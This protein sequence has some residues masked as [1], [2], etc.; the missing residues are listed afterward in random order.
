[1]YVCMHVCMYVCM[2]VCMHVRMYSCM[3]AYMYGSYVQIIYLYVFEISG[4][5]AS[6]FSMKKHWK[7]R[8]T[9]KSAPVFI[10]FELNLFLLIYSHGRW[11]Q[12]RNTNHLHYAILA[13]KN[14]FLRSQRG[15]CNGKRTPSQFKN[16]HNEERFI[17]L[18][19]YKLGDFRVNTV[20][21]SEVKKSPRPTNFFFVILFIFVM[22]NITMWTPYF[23]FFFIEKKKLA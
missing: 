15:A 23:H 7:M 22:A 10:F 17:K 14:H 4:L 16:R 21:W 19:K 13:T 12:T 20:L 3:Y 1:M 18:K 8:Q 11:L 9:F 6:S 5:V 2:H